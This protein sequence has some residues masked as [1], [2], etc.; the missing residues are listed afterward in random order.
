MGKAL[1]I[2]SGFVTAP[3]TTLTALT[4]ATGNSLNVRAFN[5]PSKAWL[6][7]NWTDSQGVGQ[8]QMKS[9]KFHDNVQGINIGTV[10]SEVQPLMPLGIPQKLYSQDTI[11]ALLSGS[12][13]AGDIETAA[14]LNYYEDLPGADARLAHWDEVKDRIESIMI[15]TNTL[16]TGTAGGWSGQEAINAE[17]DNWQANRDYVLLGY[18]TTLECAAIRWQGSDTANLGVGGPG[19]ESFKELTSWWFRRL[20]VAFDLPLM[21]I[22]NAANKSSI[23][24][25][26]AQDENGADPLVT[27]IFGLLAE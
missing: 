18:Q 16:S 21:P 24:I 17:V 13:T 15:S 27:S 7:T 5:D 3:S 19:N 22:F 2:N 14:W 6:L 9:P 1:E 10:I 26:C 25:D 8:F 12:A 11:S 23:L 4:M 20:S